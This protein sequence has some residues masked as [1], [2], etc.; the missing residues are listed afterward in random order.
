MRISKEMSEHTIIF[1]NVM[2]P[3]VIAII[4]IS[5]TYLVTIL[6]EKNTEKK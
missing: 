4:G 3:L 5:I 1:E 2:F 6:K